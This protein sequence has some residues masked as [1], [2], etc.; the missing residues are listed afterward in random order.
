MADA[1]KRCSRVNADLAATRQASV[2]I[3]LAELQADNTLRDLVARADQALCKE[4]QW[5]RSAAGGRRFPR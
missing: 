5:L 2:T 1:A 4:R 3:G